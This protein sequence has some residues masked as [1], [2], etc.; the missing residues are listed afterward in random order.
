VQF[1]HEIARIQ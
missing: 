1:W